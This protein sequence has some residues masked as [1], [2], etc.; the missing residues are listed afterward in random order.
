MTVKLYKAK[1]AAD[2]IEANA[3]AYT[4]MKPEPAKPEPKKT[5]KEEEGL[6]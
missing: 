5:K 4:T 6:N 2:E 3:P 1:A